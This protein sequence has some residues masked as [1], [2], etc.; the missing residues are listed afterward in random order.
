MWDLIILVPDY[1][2]SFYLCLCH[3]ND[4][5]RYQLNKSIICGLFYFLLNIMLTAIYI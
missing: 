1:R 4:I 5:M 3:K 2:F